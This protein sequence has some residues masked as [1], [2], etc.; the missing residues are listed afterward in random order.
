MNP[1]ILDNLVTLVSGVNDPGTY[2]N[3]HIPFDGNIDFVIFARDKIS[4]PG[5][6]YNRAG[7]ATIKFRI[8]DITGN[9]VYPQDAPSYDLR[10]NLIGDR[11][12]HQENDNYPN[13]VT[14]NVVPYLYCYSDCGDQDSPAD[15]YY[16]QAGVP[17]YYQY[18]RYYITNNISNPQG[19]FAGDFNA[20]RDGI[21]QRDPYVLEVIVEDFFGRS[22]TETFD[23][24]F[25]FTP[26]IERY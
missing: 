12:F 9:Q 21:P 24:E 17:T 10:V 11:V 15:P 22:D 4:I 23:I 2:I 8:L 16:N 14:S 6:G 13:F 18:V 26:A 19:S 20:E 5:G 25:D 1:E 7:L 3:T